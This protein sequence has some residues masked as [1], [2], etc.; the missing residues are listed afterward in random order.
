MGAAFLTYVGV[1][2]QIMPEANKL[3]CTLWMLCDANGKRE[4]KQHRKTKEFKGNH[5]LD[6]FLKI[7]EKTP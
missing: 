6:L 1:F 3:L 7:M 5:T 4:R 2:S